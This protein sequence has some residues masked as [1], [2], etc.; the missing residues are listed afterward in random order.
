MSNKAKNLISRTYQK[1][2]C[3]I[4]K[5]PFLFNKLDV[6]YWNRDAELKKDASENILLLDDNIISRCDIA[7]REQ[8]LKLFIKVPRSCI[9]S[10]AVLE[11]DFRR[12]NDF[13]YSPI[14]SNNKDTIT[15]K[16]THNHNIINFNKEIDLNETDFKPIS[17]LQLLSFN[18]GESYPF[19]DRLIE[20]LSNSAITP[21]DEIPDNIERAQKVMEQNHHYFK[22]PGL[23]EEKMQK[24][25]YDYLMSTGPIQA[26][27]TSDKVKLIDQRHGYH[28]KLGHKSKSNL[29]DVLGY[30]D[31]DA[32]KWYASW[33]KD[34]KSEATVQNTIQNVD[35][36]NGIFDI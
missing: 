4:F 7:N 21:I 29:Y 28:F 22:I 34:T 14:K 6:E 8:D 11:G 24:I 9:S 32:E 15:W 2:N 35:I 3:S 25:I 27:K 16:Y 12:F 36:Y 18:T 17:K 23:W 33:K 13:N 30:I 5:Q 1:V 10:I 31:K 20:Y 19:A 26:D